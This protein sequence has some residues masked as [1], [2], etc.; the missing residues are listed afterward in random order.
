M[1]VIVFL[2]DGFE[3]V[4]AITVV[5]YLRR[6]E[7]IQVDMVAVGDELSVRGA[8]DIVI[9]ADKLIEDIQ[10]KDYQALVIPG[11]M[12]GAKNLRENKDVVKMVKS[13]YDSNKLLAAICAGPIVLEEAGILDGKSVT[14]YPGFEA[15]LKNCDYQED[16]VVQDGKIITARGPYLAVDFSLALV[17]NLLGKERRRDL[18]K[19][20]L[21]KS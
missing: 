9:R 6:M 10:E 2:A 18:E 8:H 14:S 15:E 19:D 1:K 3:E 16:S 4:E 17:E 11:G 21:Y 13:L 7:E 5:D 12:P 20:I